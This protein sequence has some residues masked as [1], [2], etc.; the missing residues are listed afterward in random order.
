MKVRVHGIGISLVGFA[1]GTARA[2]Q[3]AG[4]KDVRIGGGV[5]ALRQ[6]LQARA[7]DE[8]HVATHAIL[9]RRD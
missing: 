7:I 1:A 9:R 4:E 5:Q 3:A 8:M 6:G 2:Q